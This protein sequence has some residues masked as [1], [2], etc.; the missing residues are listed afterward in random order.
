MKKT[1][2]ILTFITAMLAGAVAAEAGWKHT[3]PVLIVTTP[4]PSFNGVDGH[5]E[6]SVNGA[7]VAANKVEYFYCTVDGAAAGSCYFRNAK[8]ETA[9]CETSD[10]DLVAEIQ[11]VGAAS[12]IDLDWEEFVFLGRTFRTC[13]YIDVQNGSPFAP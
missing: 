2:Y 4:S 8:G 10:P 9:S 1:A 5:A 3:D 12:Y 7:T 11:T 6:A 13:T